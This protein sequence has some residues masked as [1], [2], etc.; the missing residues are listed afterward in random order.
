MS[1]A[2]SLSAGILFCTALR[3][4]ALHLYTLISNG[5]VASSSEI[6]YSRLALFWSIYQAIWKETATPMRHTILT[7]S[8]TGRLRDGRYA[9]MVQD[10]S[11]QVARLERSRTCDMRVWY[12]RSR[13]GDW[14]SSQSRND[15]LTYGV[16]RCKAEPEENFSWSGWMTNLFRQS[17]V[18]G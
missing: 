9:G 6:R 10:Y 12:T 1:N 5:I 14:L 18:I 3:R 16:F 7:R 13:H 2:R 17:K 4:F 11:L 8:D 15:A